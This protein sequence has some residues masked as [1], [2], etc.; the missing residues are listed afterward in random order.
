MNRRRFVACLATFP[1]LRMTARSMA[2]TSS[3]LHPS[4]DRPTTI[5]LK[6][7]GSVMSS[8][9]GEVIE[10]LDISASNENGVTVRHQNVTLRNC[11]IRHAQ[12]HGVRGEGAVQLN[13][14]DLDI[15][16]V[17][18]PPSGPTRDGSFNN[19]DLDGCP[20]AVMARLRAARGAANIYAL[21]SERLHM[22]DLELHDA[23]G[24]EPRGQN[25]QLDKSPNSILESFSGENGP[26]SWT[27]DNI[28]LFESD[29]CDVR[30]GLVS[31][32]N[33][34]TG[35]GIMMEG[36]FNCT[37][38][39]IDAL[40]QGDGAF[41]A[42]P[43][44][45][46]GCGGCTFLRCRTANSY[47]TPRDGRPAPASNGLSIYTRISKDAQKHSVVDCH[48]RALANPH[49]LIWEVR[50]L[51]PGWSFTPRNF[52]PRAPVRLTFAW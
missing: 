4:G 38:T 26:T 16:N 32:N 48:Y 20:G 9:D 17:G 14:H 11:R 21:R 51:N 22:S 6:P 49:N 45:N 8:S 33:S 50:A 40:M 19:V 36:S 30:N 3:P 43:S 2:A 34:P 44:D 46:A 1:S 35:C 47:N 29:N 41:A 37:A 28:S 39:D 5:A 25:V 23:R 13:L 31:Y 52:V 27:E 10:N 12:G 42:V 18:A 7:T 15:V 24:P